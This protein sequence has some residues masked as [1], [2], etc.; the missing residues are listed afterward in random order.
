M[1]YSENHASAHTMIGSFRRFGA[2]GPA[3][4]II[5]AAE[6]EQWLDVR[7]VDTGESLHYPRRD[8]LA[9]PEA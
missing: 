6:D 1:A 2:Y 7:V 5:G 4:E 3:Y 8:A 9:D